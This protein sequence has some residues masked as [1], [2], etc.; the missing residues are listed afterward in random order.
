MNQ[1]LPNEQPTEQPEDDRP[2][3]NG[4]RRPVAY[5]LLLG[6]ALATFFNGEIGRGLSISTVVV[7]VA[8]LGLLLAGAA[9]FYS[10]RQRPD[11]VGDYRQVF[12]SLES[13]SEIDK[14]AQSKET[15]SDRLE[16]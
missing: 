4:W 11:R 5:L 9:L 10:V 8:A 14:P 16:K 12:R 15:P 2:K 7:Q 6:G 13:S 3:P 1:P